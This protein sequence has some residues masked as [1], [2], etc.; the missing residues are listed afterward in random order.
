MQH[1][2]F[3]TFYHGAYHN[4]HKTWPNR[5][6]H[7]IG[8]LAG[9]ALLVA[10]VTIMPLWCAL[11][12]PV[13]HALP[14]LIGHR[15]FERNFV[16]GDLRFVDGHYPPLWFIVANHIMTWEVLARPFGWRRIT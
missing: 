11:A 16:L 2:P 12:F 1:S 9:L 14:G 13:V 3:W 7:I 6:L 4:D 8:T 10:S 5:S 15:L